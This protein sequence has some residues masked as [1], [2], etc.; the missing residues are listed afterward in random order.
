M[1]TSFA[2]MQVFKAF[3]LTDFAFPCKRNYSSSEQNG[4]SQSDMPR[5]SMFE[6]L[7]IAW[8]YPFSSAWTR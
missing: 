1:V 8:G 3:F 2:L 7:G 5:G 4:L 6:L